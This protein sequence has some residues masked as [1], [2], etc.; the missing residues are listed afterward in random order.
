MEC[1][2]YRRVYTLVRALCPLPTRCKVDTLTVV[3]FPS[4]LAP[5]PLRSLLSI[6]NL[7][8]VWAREDLS[9]VYYSIHIIYV[10]C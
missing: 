1:I 2:I 6:I 3:L 7:N 10:Y 8:R 4:P 5:P 9:I